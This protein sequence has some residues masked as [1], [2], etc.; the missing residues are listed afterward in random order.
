MPPP[1]VVPGT[2]VP[3]VVAVPLPPELVTIAPPPVVIPPVVLEQPPVVVPPEA[4]PIY[5]APHR[6]RKQDRH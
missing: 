3:T 1:L 4:P 5:V 2:W 6:P